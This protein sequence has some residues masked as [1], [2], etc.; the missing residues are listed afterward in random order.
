MIFEYRKYNL[1]NSILV[2]STCMGKNH[3]N[4]RVALLKLSNGCLVTVYILLLFLMVPWVGLQC[5]IV[6]FP[7]HIHLFFNMG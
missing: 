1:S 3:K 5:V 7:D 6:I 2:I 4:E